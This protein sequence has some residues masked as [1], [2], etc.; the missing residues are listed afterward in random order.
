MTK[1]TLPEIIAALPAGLTVEASPHNNDGDGWATITNAEGLRFSLYVNSYRG[2]ATAQAGGYDV[3]TVRAYSSDVYPSNLRAGE[4][5]SSLDG[6]PAKIAASLARRVFNHPDFIAEASAI[7]AV[8]DE[9]TKQRATLRDGIARLQAMGFHCSELRNGET[10]PMYKYD[11][12]SLYRPGEPALTL[13]GNGQITFEVTVRTTLDE[14]PATLA[15]VAALNR[16]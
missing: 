13:Y 12:V 15:H 3:D 4:A 14:L 16:D 2:K 9:R 8:F 5:S 6:D 10:V 11:R 7:R 1:A